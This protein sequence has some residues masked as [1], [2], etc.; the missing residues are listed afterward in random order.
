[1]N[2]TGSTH[3]HV[4]QA[5][6]LA[7]W[8]ALIAIYITWGST[9][10]AIR[11]AVE[12]MPPFFMAAIR[13][14]IAGSILFAWRRLAGDPLP[15][16][17]QWRSAAVVGL[18]LLLGGNGAIVWA[19]QTLPSGI[20]SLMIG[21][22]PLWMVLLDALR[23]GGRLPAWQAL[24]G[25]VIGFG[26]ILLLFLPGQAV[27]GQALPLGGLLVVFLGSSLWATGSLYSRHAALP[28]SPLM[29]TAMEMLAGGAGLLVAGFLTGEP[30]QL[31][32]AEITSKSLL[33]LA[34]LIVFGSLVGFAC[35]TWLLRSA[36]TSLVS[37]Y[38][39]VNPVVAIF[40]GYLLAG[41]QLNFRTLVAAA[42]ILGSVVLTTR[43]GNKPAARA[44]PVGVGDD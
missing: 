8:A 44:A 38:A 33:G 12:T 14:F 27:G 31:H 21:T 24:L 16:R 42:I 17:R 10:L 15:T 32:L 18:F 9:Y 39:Y 11:F 6:S 3:E 41:E 37:T 30:A 20:A 43:V 29:G 36:P 28:A 4:N 25:V 5:S 22:V 7:I 40:M 35:Y 1:M 2:S 23:P 34:Y 13:F 26:G 19:E